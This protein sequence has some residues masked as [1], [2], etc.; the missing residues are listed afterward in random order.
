MAALKQVGFARLGQVAHR[1]HGDDRLVKIRDRLLCCLD[2]CIQLLGQGPDGFFIILLQLGQVL[3]AQNIL[4]QQ[5]QDIFRQRGAAEL[6][7]KTGRAAG[8]NDL[9][10]QVILTLR[11]RELGLVLIGR[12]AARGIVG[13]RLF[14]VE[15]H[16]DRVIAAE[17]DHHLTCGSRR[18]GPIKISRAV[19][20]DGDGV[21]LAILVVTRFP[22]FVAVLLGQV[23]LFLRAPILFEGGVL[24]FSGEAAE[25]M[26]TA[27]RRRCRQLAG[28]VVS[29]PLVRF[30]RAGFGLGALALCGGHAVAAL[31]Q[32]RAL[33]H[34]GHLDHRSRVAVARLIAS[35]GV[36]VEV[37]VK[38]VVLLL[39]NRIVL[40]V[41]TLGTFHRQAQPDIGGRL[42]T[43]DI[44]LDA[45]LLL[46]QPALVS[47]AV[48]A[49]EAGSHLILE[50]RVLELVAGQLLHRE[51][52]E[53]FVVVVRADHPVAPRPHEPHA[54]VVKH[55]RVA[56]PRCVHPRQCHPL[57]V[58]LARQQRVNKHLVGVRVGVVDE[59]LDSL[60]RRRQPSQIETDPADECPAIHLRRRLQPV[61][62]HPGQREKIDRVPWPSGALHAG[63][64]RALGRDKRPV[65]LPLRALL[66]P[67]PDR[68]DLVRRHHLLGFRRRHPVVGVVRGD[69]LVQQTC[70]R[71]ARHDNPLVFET[72]KQAVLGV[73]P[74]LGLAMSLVR[75]VALHAVMRQ[76]WPHLHP[77]P[78]LPR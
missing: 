44:V 68:G 1:H 54:V 30:L 12:R 36:D 3:G 7:I 18:H 58:T 23:H 76:Q 10:Q 31:L 16:L 66:D 39:R 45:V 60:R 26:P 33:G 71:L 73:E 21:H 43:V 64:S 24:V 59:P 8:V 2:F 37:G 61:G 52:V 27:Q 15:E 38:L 77:K 40:V 13:E 49:V 47:R 56:V 65:A 28:A 48:V 32:L 25:E 50:R 20:R 78:H 62:L 35:V 74:Q 69:F 55:A 14:A 5:R 63:Q 41:V 22:F 72:A 19:L 34:A 53:P 57:A 75:A 42:D 9:E 46:D 29:D 70:V 11:Q 17:R 51:F 67:A 6:E 4:C